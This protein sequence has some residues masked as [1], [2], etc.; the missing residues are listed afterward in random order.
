[1]S[2]WSEKESDSQSMMQTSL[3][4]QPLNWNQLLLIVMRGKVL[5]LQ[6]LPELERIRSKDVFCQIKIPVLLLVQCPS[7]VQRNLI[8]KL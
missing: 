6:P 5:I 4:Y 3:K 1:M 8:A 7:G 2:L